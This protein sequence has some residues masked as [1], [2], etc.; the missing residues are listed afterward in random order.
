M[1]TH[2]VARR[3]PQELAF[4]E[5]A[6]RSPRRR[7]HVRFWRQAAPDERG[8]TLWFGA[9]SFDA[10]VGVSRFTG[11]VMHH[12]D[13][14]IDVERDKLV[15]DL[16]RAGRVTAARWIP[17]FAVA[18]S[19]RNGGGDRWVTD[20]R[21]AV[22]RLFRDEPQHAGPPL[23]DPEVAAGAPQRKEIA[24]STLEDVARLAGR[25]HEER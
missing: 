11:E 4:E 1:S 17:G 23:A 10:S 24:I 2:F 6:G 21:L 19:G 22:V 8:R 3:R 14:A 25:V 20:R 13:P 9:A 7:H 12:I 16:S 15:A 5:L 18:P